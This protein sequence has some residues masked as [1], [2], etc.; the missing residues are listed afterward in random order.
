MYQVVLIIQCTCI[1]AVLC[2]I[3]IVLKNW[4]DKLHS[5]LFLSCIATLVNSIGYLLE[6]LSDSEEAYYMALKASW[7]GRVW[8]SFALFL[9]IVEIVKLKIPYVVRIIL[10]FIN[11]IQFVIILLTP[12]TGLYYLNPEFKMDGDFPDFQFEAGPMQ[13]FWKLLLVGY[14]I[15][16]LF[17]LFREVYREKD[18]VGKKRLCTV[19]TAIFVESACT[20]INMF[21]SVRFLQVYDLT[22]IGFTI[23]AVFIFVAIFKYNLMDTESLVKDY[24]IDEISAG[25]IAADEDDNVDFY[26][27][28]ALSL[29][30]ELETDTHTVLRK[31]KDSISSDEPISISGRLYSPEEKII[32]RNGSRVEKAYVLVDSTGHYRHIRE[33]EEKVGTVLAKVVASDKDMHYLA[34]ISQK[35]CG[36][37]VREKDRYCSHCGEKL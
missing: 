6:L 20:I 15:F 8:I 1:I 4:H 11:V 27:K 21:R 2:E 36:E 10:G 33:L 19:I 12:K 22:M 28:T 14:I 31:L 3:W 37:K 18:I 25:V 26:N 24:M 7:V 16:G 35:E 29:F 13:K 32:D 17:L 5:Y 23:G 9:F 34:V 30:P